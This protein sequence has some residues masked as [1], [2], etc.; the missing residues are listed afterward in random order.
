VLYSYLFRRTSGPRYLTWLKGRRLGDHLALFC[1]HRVNSRNDFVIIIGSVNIVAS[2]SDTIT[3]YY[4]TQ[5]V[6]A[7]YTANTVSA[8]LAHRETLP[9]TPV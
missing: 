1:I 8:I 5:S 2:E 4:I 7:V 3:H 9:F 6:T